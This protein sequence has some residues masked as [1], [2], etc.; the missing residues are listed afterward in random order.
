MSLVMERKSIRKYSNKEIKDSIILKL[1]KSAMQAPSACNQQP[2]EF[3][4]IDDEET[5]TKLS[6]MSSGA[7]MLGTVSKAIAV[8]MTN[9]T[10]SPLMREQDCAAATQNI[11]LEATHLGLG[12]CWI[13]V[14]PKMDR[15]ELADRLLNVPSESHVFSLISLGYPEKEEQIKERFDPLRIKYNRY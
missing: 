15:V 11:L 13:G 14:Y 3:V 12:S 4:V 1:L 5:L 2:W 10:K 9:T 7:W 6:K 8:I